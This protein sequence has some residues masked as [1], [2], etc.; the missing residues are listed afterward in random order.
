MDIKVVTL[1]LSEIMKI[2]LKQAKK[3]R[4]ISLIKILMSLYLKW[5]C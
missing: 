4:I 3:G 1:L 5:K 2:A